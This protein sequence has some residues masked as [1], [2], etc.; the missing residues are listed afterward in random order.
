MSIYI[1]SQ[2]DYKPRFILS[3]SNGPNDRYL[4]YGWNPID[5]FYNDL[6]LTEKFAKQNNLT[7]LQIFDLQK[8]N[9]LN[10]SEI[11]VVMS[12]GSIGYHFPIEPYIEEL[13]KITKPDCIMI[14]GLSTDAYPWCPYN[15]KSFECYFNS[16]KIIQNNHLK[17][18]VS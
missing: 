5:G 7:N 8:E 17:K 14:F 1:N 4:R 9:L 3:D 10:L 15:E 12:F 16:V 2:L 11:D 18:M 13:L 6:K